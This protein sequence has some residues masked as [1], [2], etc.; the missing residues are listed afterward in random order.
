V[1]ERGARQRGCGLFF[2]INK[3]YRIN[4]INLFY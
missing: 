2:I 4:Q 1:W 3:T